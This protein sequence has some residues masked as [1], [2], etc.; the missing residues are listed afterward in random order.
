MDALKKKVYLDNGAEIGYD[1]C[2]IATGELDL[3]DS[4]LVLSP[5]L[6]GRAIRS[7]NMLQTVR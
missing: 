2:L 5:F 4:S 1:K 3:L 7:L 6:I